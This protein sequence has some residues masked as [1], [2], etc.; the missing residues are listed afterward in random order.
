MSE[1]DY[2]EETVDS[3]AVIE[4]S[5]SPEGETQHPKAKSR[6]KKD[7]H[8]ERNPKRRLIIGGTIAVVVLALIAVGSIW[9]G[10]RTNGEDYHSTTRTAFVE[11]TSL[12]SSFQ[13]PGRLGYGEAKV[14][15]GGGGV[16]T[17]IP[18]AGSSVKAGEVI[19][20]VE[21]APVFMLQGELP[22]WREIGPGA[23]GPDV[24]ALRAALAKIG[25]AAGVAGNQTYD[26][27]LSDAIGRLYLK[28]GYQTP[29][30]SQS[31]QVVVTQAR[32]TLKSAE[33]G[34]ADAREYLNTVKNTKPSSSDLVAASNAVNYAQRVYLAAL[35]GSCPTDMDPNKGCTPD[36][37]AAALD[38][39]NLAKA[40]LN[41]LN[42]PPDT[43]TAQASVNQAQRGVN[44]ASGALSLA[45]QNTVSPESVLIVPEAEIRID[46]V[47]A[48]VGLPATGSI[49][50]WTQTILFGW[51]ELTESQR[52]LLSTG[53]Q[54]ILRL[55]DGTE[56]TGLV[57]EI[58][59]A[60]RDPSSGQTTPASVRIDIDDQDLVTEIGTSSA[61]I[62][63]IQDEVEDSLVVPV[64]ALM[65]LAEG[66]YCVELVDGTL[67]GV[68]VGLIAD[69]RAQV[70]STELKE[71]DEVIVP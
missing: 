5:E 27:A 59:D 43:T 40:Q 44:E 49:L 12:V 35:R 2:A 45:L 66:G 20:E 8:Q 71:G 65:A 10:N 22:L 3:T 56:I 50:T 28:A 46:N 41:D 6:R 62:S 25:I 4:T 15:G 34:L 24:A 38:N 31:R 30:L 7:R 67:I 61:T 52:R 21:G 1:Q 60:T 70:F 26:T 48:K 19:M 23:A 39:L 14:L 51:A 63:F 32:E 17:K 18:Q 68:E 9:L 36:E 33:Q 37:V 11:R 69:T 58:T 42:K 13:L 64:T 57:G 54:A 29:P 47:M 53:M 55:S 16:V